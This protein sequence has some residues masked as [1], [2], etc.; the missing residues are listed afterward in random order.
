MSHYLGRVDSFTL[1]D[2]AWHAL[3]D[4]VH[5]GKELVNLKTLKSNES[6]L[7]MV[8]LTMILGAAHDQVKLCLCVKGLL[9]L[10]FPYTYPILNPQDVDRC[11]S[12][13]SFNYSPLQRRYPMHPN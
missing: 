12:L 10:A 8:S 7:G 2:D 1:N 5:A 6:D 4:G 3:N 13:F 11:R 9:P